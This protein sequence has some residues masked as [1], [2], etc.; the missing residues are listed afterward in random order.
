MCSVA[1]SSQPIEIAIR[2]TGGK[3]L[4]YFQASAL[5]T[6]FDSGFFRLIEPENGKMYLELARTP[7]EFWSAYGSDP[8]L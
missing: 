1:S 7:N 8:V 5:Q 3:Q 6:L 4:G 2:T